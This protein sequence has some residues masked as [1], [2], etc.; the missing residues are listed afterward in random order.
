VQPFEPGLCSVGD[1]FADQVGRHGQVN[2]FASQYRKADELTDGILADLEFLT[3][4]EWGRS[5]Y[6]GLDGGELRGFV[7]DLRTNG[8][9]LTDS[10]I[11]TALG[12]PMRG[13]L[14]Q[15][16]REQ[17]LFEKKT[18]NAGVHGLLKRYVASRQMWYFETKLDRP[19]SANFFVAHHVALAVG[20]S[21]HG[22]RLVG[23]LTYQFLTD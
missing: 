6:R 1:P 17:D 21:P 12:S 15:K 23:V 14:T 22:N 20:R 11:R 8:A 4:V 3:S 13:R 16:H 7:C 18:E 2:V 5:Y 9:P 10:D 19:V